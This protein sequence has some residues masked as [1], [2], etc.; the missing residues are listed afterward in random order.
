MNT[1]C[2]EQGGCHDLALTHPLD[3]YS[4][5]LCLPENPEFSLYR[6]YCLN[7]GKSRVRSVQ[8]QQGHHGGLLKLHYTSPHHLQALL[9]VKP[10]IC[11]STSGIW[12][13]VLWSAHMWMNSTWLCSKLPFA[14][15]Y[16]SVISHS[17]CRKWLTSPPVPS[18]PLCFS[19]PPSLSL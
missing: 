19:L 15:I 5:F 1:H 9:A 17:A 3:D 7:P 4:A 11:T 2:S 14:W 16:F 12:S 6:L 18:L 8:N 13:I 10:F